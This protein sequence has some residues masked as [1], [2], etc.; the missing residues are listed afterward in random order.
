MELLY[1]CENYLQVDMSTA[2]EKVNL[3]NDIAL[4]I[5][6]LTELIFKLS[7]SGV[8]YDYLEEYLNDFMEVYGENRE[9]QVL[10]LLDEDKGLGSP[11]GYTKPI[12]HKQMKYK[13]ISVE[14]RIQ[15][16]FYLIKC[17]EL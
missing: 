13:S 17:L 6:K 4:E 7:Y 10:E 8:R 5:E 9:V 2:T 12:S 16:F 11:A 1:K 3:D 14:K 15:S